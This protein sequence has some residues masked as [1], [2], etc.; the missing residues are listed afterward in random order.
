[1]NRILHGQPH[2]VDGESTISELIEGF[3]IPR[4]G[5]Q[6]KGMGNSYPVVLMMIVA[7]LPT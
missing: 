2:Q 4:T 7:L 6:W 3:E 5:T 1:M